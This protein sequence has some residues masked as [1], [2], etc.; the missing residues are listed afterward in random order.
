MT[1]SR[2]TALSGATAL[3]ATSGA[4]ARGAASALQASQGRGHAPS[5]PSQPAQRFLELLIHHDE[6]HGQP[7]YAEIAIPSSDTAWYAVDTLDNLTYRTTNHRYMQRGYRLKRISA[8][9]TKDGTR[10][11]GCWQLASGPEWRTRH[12]MSLT[13][14]NQAC[15]EH[16]GFRLIHLNVR[17][18]YA[19][20]WEKGDASGQQVFPG[21]T[22]SEYEQQFASLTASG[23]RLSRLCGFHD[24]VARFA[25]IFEKTDGPAW[26]ARHQMDPKDFRKTIA[27][28]SAQGYHM[29]DASG[30]AEGGKATF[31]GIWEQA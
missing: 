23:Y 5:Q 21:L 9:K 12:A 28:M 25:A 30:H 15:A 4:L 6:G 31:T 17:T 13:G 7:A 11:A 27:Q 22:L 2:R 16:H 10:Y 20:I 3:V 19:A 24:G 29:V 14:F 8:F 18:H 1:I 26:Q